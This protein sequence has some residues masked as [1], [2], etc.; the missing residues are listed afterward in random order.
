[1][2]RVEELR[3]MLNE[4]SMKDAEDPSV[5]FEQVSAIRNRYDTAAHQIDEEE[6]LAVVM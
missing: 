2:S 4:V 1:M 6:L 3:T 5:L